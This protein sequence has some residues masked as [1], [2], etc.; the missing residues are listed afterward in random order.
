[1]VR[2]VDFGFNEQTGKDNEFQHRPSKHQSNQIT[3]SALAEF[4]AMVEQIR[5][6]QIEVLLLTKEHT[7]QTLPD[8]IFPNNWFS[9]RND[10]KLFIYPMK[11]ANR[12]AE[13]QIEPLTKL[14]VSANYKLTD[15]VDLRQKMNDRLVL[16]GTGSLIFA[17][18]E[19]RLFAAHSERCNSHALE[20]YASE[21]G[22]Q[23]TSFDSLS[24]N[25][26]PIYHTNV[27]MSC[28]RNFAVIATSVIAD[29]KQ[30]KQT[31]NELEQSV[32][33]I[34]TITETQ[35]AQSFCANILQLED[36]NQQPAIV[37]SNSAYK[38][39]NR[40]QVK[41]LEKHGSLIVCNI[42][43]IEHIGGGSARCMIAENFLTQY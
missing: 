7:E 19:G 40:Q 12:R 34:I 16:E 26:Q 17:H 29:Q 36:K 27:L 4:D 32:E 21:Y 33:D 18:S 24:Q 22:Y 42:P 1:M 23:L 14:L 15:I 6:Y 13:V 37:M 43:T 9:T 39:F 10:G 2:P 5:K 8:A 30:R 25:G 11:T 38:G 3:Q 28:G 20:F 35:M 41:L 31:I